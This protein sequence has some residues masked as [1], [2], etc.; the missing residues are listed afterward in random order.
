MKAPAKGKNRS[1]NSAAELMELHDREFVECAYWTLLGRPADLDGLAHYR[2]HLRKGTPKAHLLWQ[3]TRSDEG[4]AHGA[5]LPGLEAVFRCY[6]R[7]RLPLV[8]WLFVL[9]GH[10]EGKS[11]AARRCRALENSVWAVEQD[12]NRRLARIE[13]QIE[14]LATGPA[15]SQEDIELPFADQCV[16]RRARE[17]LDAL[18]DIM[19]TVG[20]EI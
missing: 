13:T 4:Q 1:A 2:R 17:L 8:G 11:R 10:A 20:P 14:K 19:P 15:S 6:R 9:F 18:S 7:A 16:T 5:I 12:L 3:L